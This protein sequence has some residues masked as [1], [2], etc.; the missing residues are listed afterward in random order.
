MSSESDEASPIIHIV[1]LGDPRRAAAI[2]PGS[3]AWVLIEDADMP[4]LGLR[5]D[6]VNPV[7]L[8]PTHPLYAGVL[9][10]TLGYRSAALQRCEPKLDTL[11]L[12]VTNRCNEAC[13]HCYDAGG[14]AEM[15]AAIDTLF[16]ATDEA[17]VLCGPTLNLLFHGGEPFLRIDVLDRV[18][19]HA[20]DQA[21]GLGKQVGV[22]VQTNASIL[23]DRII[24][25][26]QK[27]HFGVGVSLDGWAELHDQMR[28]MAD[29]TGT[30]RLFE[31]SYRRYAHYLTAHAGIMTTVMACNV[32]AL[33]EIVRHVRDLGF[34]T[35]DATLFDLSGKGALYPQLAVG[36]EAYSAALEPIL[37]LIEA[38]EC[39]EIAIKPVLRRLDNLLS[40]RRDDMCLPGNG[41]CGAGG[42]LL[43]LSA[44]NIVHGCDIIDRAS[45]RLGVFPATTFGAALASPQAAIMR[46]RPSRLAACHRCTWFGL[47]GG[48]C[49]ARG[50]LNAPDSTEC[51]V[52]KRINHSLLRRIARSD[53]LLD[54]YER[55]PPDRRRASIIS[56]TANRAAASHP[57]NTAQRPRSVS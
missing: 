22:F 15:D 8:A 34:R 41:P 31:R 2:H 11:I 48:T 5:G 45:L 4:G 1:P 20:R 35:W 49:L 43:S 51:L 54:W 47:C 37:D 3:G 14:R 13:R 52:S 30:Y 33:P 29:G 24:G 26:L 55:Y 46:S 7:E 40:P 9:D 21:A 39:D 38:G 10:A 6:T 27:H 12:K 16:D 19:A 44:E 53:R 36:G 28:V 42:R 23:N 17:L 56:E 25:I 50:S 57:V 32:G 18:A